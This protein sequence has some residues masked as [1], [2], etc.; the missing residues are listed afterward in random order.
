MKL[1]AFR[2]DDQNVDFRRR[3]YPC[4]P[5]GS[6]V[7]AQS[8]PPPP[9]TSRR[10]SWP[11]K[12]AEP[13]H[14]W[15]WLPLHAHLHP[16]PFAVDTSSEQHPVHV[17]GNEGTYDVTLT[18]PDDDGATN[19]TTKPVDVAAG[20]Q[21]RGGDSSE[22]R[23]YA[24]PLPRMG[25]RC[26]R[27]LRRRRVR[28]RRERVLVSQRLRR[29]P[30][31]AHV[32]SRRSCSMSPVC[33]PLPRPRSRRAIYRCR[34]VL[35]RC[36]RAGYRNERHLRRRPSLLPRN[37]RYVAPVRQAETLPD[38]P[39]DVFA[40]LQIGPAATTAF[41]L[42]GPAPTARGRAASAN[43]AV[44]CDRG[45]ARARAPPK[46]LGS[47]DPLSFRSSNFSVAQATVTILPSRCLVRLL[48]GNG[49]TQTSDASLPHRQ[50]RV[51]NR[52]FH[53]HRWR[54]M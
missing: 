27:V 50:D 51:H 12:L 5:I 10:I 19:S 14:S 26:R 40:A 53:F 18:V 37:R 31:Y 15:G 32:A 49:G 4:D 9:C 35:R 22:D 54:S 1:F 47:N 34:L 24:I 28:R 36:G 44:S 21:Q 43:D 33:R 3:A 20:K 39:A 25:D 38:R 52:A 45:H 42:H 17:Y 23:S 48:L 29:M 46:A 30:R 13:R 2:T 7:T 8:D 16:S 6:R 11:P 41:R